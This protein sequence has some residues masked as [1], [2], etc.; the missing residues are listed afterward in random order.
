MGLFSRKVNPAERALVLDLLT[1]VTG[2]ILKSAEVTREANALISKIPD[3][4]PDKDFD[5]NWLR[6][7]DR[8]NEIR[9][10][11]CGNE[12]FWP[13]IEDKRNLELV[14]DLRKKLGECLK[15][16]SN[17]MRLTLKTIKDASTYRKR[18]EQEKI[19][20]KK[21]FEQLGIILAKLAGYYNISKDER[22]KAQEN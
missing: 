22:K 10:E 3:Y 17:D 8:V 7:M 14:L 6:L 9:D 2:A 16:Q 18:L 13:K 15:Y 4:I 21:S 1:R 20:L 12:A 5:S 11:T 19:S